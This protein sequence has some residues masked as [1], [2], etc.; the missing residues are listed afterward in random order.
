MD[1]KRKI[2]FKAESLPALI[3]M[4]MEGEFEG[5]IHAAVVNESH[6]GCCLVTRNDEVLEEG[7]KIRVRVGKIAELPAKVVWIKELDK[8]V[9]KFGLEYLA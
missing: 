4:D 2:R 1:N 3:E 7:M 5:Q 9:V 8:D 6:A